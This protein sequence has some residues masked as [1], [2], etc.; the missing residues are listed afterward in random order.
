MAERRSEFAAK[1]KN[2]WAT[3]PTGISLAQ[4]TCETLEGAESLIT[5]LFKNTLIADVEEYK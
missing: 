2:V 3:G 1:Y 5:R 4:F